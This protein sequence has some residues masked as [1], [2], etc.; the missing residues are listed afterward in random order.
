MSKAWLALVLAP[1]L[2]FAKPPKLTLFISVDS[3]GSDVFL[4][5]RPRFKAGLA[6]LVATGALFP[7]ARYEI[8][9]AHV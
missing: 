3:L 7:T 1:S 5:N 8:G 6:Q 2:A 4:R 9:R